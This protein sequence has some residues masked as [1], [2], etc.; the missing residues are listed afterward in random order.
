MSPE[1]QRQ[2]AREGGLTVSRDRRHMADIGR[3][4]G[5]RSHSGGR[6]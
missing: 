3:V 1:T 4:G 5:R 2:L 6:H